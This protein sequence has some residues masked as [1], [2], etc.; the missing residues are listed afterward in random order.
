MDELV[1][2]AFLPVVTAARELT[3]AVLR[4]YRYGKFTVAEAGD[5]AGEGDES[6][7]KILDGST[8]RKPGDSVIAIRAAS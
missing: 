5:C 4:T 8:H 1:L 2:R 7:P 6:I 3:A